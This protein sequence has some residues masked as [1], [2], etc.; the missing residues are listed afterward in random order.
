[1]KTLTCAVRWSQRQ[2]QR[3]VREQ[4]QGSFW[5]TH[6]EHVAEVDEHVV[7]LLHSA[8]D[9]EARRNHVTRLAALV[10]VVRDGEVEPSAG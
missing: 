9:V 3:L 6:L 10:E 1:M 2:R 8:R 5:K 4:Q 7:R